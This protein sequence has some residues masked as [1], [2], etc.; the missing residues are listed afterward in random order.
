VVVSGSLEQDASIRPSSENAEITMIVL[1]IVE[2]FLST[3]DSSQLAS[4]DVLAERFVVLRAPAISYHF[5]P[6]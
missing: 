5:E 1:F 4:P 3:N 2:L 6:L